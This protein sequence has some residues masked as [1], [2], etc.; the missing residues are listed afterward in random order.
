[1]RELRS[2]VAAV[3]LPL[4]LV[5]CGVQGD[6]HKVTEVREATG[7][8][9]ISNQTSL[10]V[11]VRVGED[12]RV[13]ITVDENLQDRVHAEVVEGELRLT[14][15]GLFG[16]SEGRIDVSAPKVT[17]LSNGASGNLTLDGRQEPGM[18][19][20]KSTGSGSLSFCVDAV[21]LLIISTASGEVQLCAPA[22]AAGL[23][24]LKIVGEASGAIAW[25]G[26]A[27][28]VDVI[29]KGSGTVTLEGNGEALMVQHHGSGG[30]LARGFVVQT[31]QLNVGG[32]GGLEATV[33]RAATVILTGSGNVDL[34]G[35]AT[36]DIDDRGTGGVSRH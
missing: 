3:L 4:V 14:T 30:I 16:W 6:G 11:H 2:V 28:E 29:H 15:S 20:V 7:F 26:V 24:R 19:T 33:E 23:Q 10:D 31:A 9:S 32:S 27:T 18:L 21:E 35:A 25:T 12:A 22:G 1:M 13:E 8:T 17:A 5:G 36:F 34:W